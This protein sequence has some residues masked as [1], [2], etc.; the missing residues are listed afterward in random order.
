MLSYSFTTTSGHDSEDTTSTESPLC[1]PFDTHV[2]EAHIGLQLDLPVGGISK[3]NTDYPIVGLQL[4][5]PVG[6]IRRPRPLDERVI[7]TNILRQPPNVVQGW[8]PKGSFHL[9]LMEN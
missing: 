7:R 4:D 5:L 1:L 9:I 3:L 8:I 6:G 2:S